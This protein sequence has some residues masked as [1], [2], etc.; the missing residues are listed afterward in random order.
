MT[1]GAGALRSGASL[2][3]TAASLAALAP[4]AD[5]VAG[6][7]AW[8][9][10]NLHAV[11]TVLTA[12]ATLR[13]ETRGGHLRSDFPDA[14]E[15]WRGHLT[16]QA[17]RRRRA[18][19]DVRPGATRPDR[20]ARPD[21]PDRLVGHHRPPW[22]GGARVSLLPGVPDEVVRDVVRRALDEDLGGP[23]GVDV[24][25]SATIPLEQS[26]RVQVVARA[27]G[28]VAGLPLFGAVWADV[29]HRLGCPPVQVR[30]RV[31]D[32]D[33][34]RRDDVLVEA[35]GATQ[36]LLVGERTALNLVCRLSGVATHTRRWADALQGTGTTVLD[37]RKT[38]PGLRALEKYA[39]RAGG[40][41]NKRMG[42]HDVAMIKDNHKPGCR[43]GHRGLRRRPRAVPRRRR[44]GRGD[45]GRRGAGGGGGR[46]A[47]PAV[48]QHDAR[49]CCGRPSR[50]CAP[51]CPSGSR[52]RAPAT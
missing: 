24:T 13:E 12:A 50:R 44:A 3:A 46:R 30:D 38:T 43:L 23:D 47:V 19:A 2:T 22:H 40:G 36:A 21:R 6:P 9:T 26:S 31:S 48:R 33:R 28:V 18:R 39:V 42:L 8:E 4:S 14:R 25:S 41:T 5:A 51:P 37:T 20:P 52:S 11:A 1:A 16:A 29:A 32:G 27:D 45:D 34:V 35:R 17:R 10:T 7:A 15:A 49:A